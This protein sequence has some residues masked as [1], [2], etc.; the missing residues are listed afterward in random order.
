MSLVSTKQGLTAGYWKAAST[1]HVRLKI[2]LLRELM[3]KILYFKG[4]QQKVGWIR[5]F[6]IVAAPRS[7]PMMPD[8]DA[9]P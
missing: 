9:A 1:A 3:M 4:Q 2:P 6:P 5:V 8:L 7:D